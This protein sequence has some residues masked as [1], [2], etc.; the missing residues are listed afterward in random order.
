[1][2]RRDLPP[3]HRAAEIVEDVA[4]LRIVRVVDDV[5]EQLGVGTAGD[6]LEKAAGLDVAAASYAC[7]L[8]HRA[9]TLDD[10]RLVKQQATHRW[11][12]AEETGEF[13]GPAWACHH[14]VGDPKLRRDIDRSRDPRTH[15]HLD[16]PLRGLRFAHIRLAFLGFPI[17]KVSQ[18]RTF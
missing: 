11:I 17:W 10:V 13:I 14:V 18:S 4:G 5:A 3:S 2:K 7:G 1:V 15:C 6:C 16:Q 9:R 12:A 8:Q